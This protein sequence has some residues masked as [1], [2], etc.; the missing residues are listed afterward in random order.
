MAVLFFYALKL[1]YERYVV[2][3][4]NEQVVALVKVLL[5]YKETALTQ[6]SNWLNSH[7]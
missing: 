5:F 4:R 1:P 7:K 3:F 6:Y 2:F